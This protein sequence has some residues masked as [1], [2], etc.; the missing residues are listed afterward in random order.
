MD[1]TDA[2][3]GNRQRVVGFADVV[4]IPLRRWRLVVAAAGVVLLAVLAYLFILPATYRAT[5]V[6]VLRPVV[7]DP[8]TLPAGGAD[9]AVNMTAENGV[10]LG[11]EVIDATA[12]A[13]ARE[14]DDVRDAL[15]VE[16]PPG[17]QVLRFEY[18]DSTEGAA[19]TGANAAA[20]TY[21]KVREGI[22][23]QQR[24]SLL[25][26]YDSTMR[27]V[28]EQRQEAQRGLPDTGRLQNIPPR[29]QAML[30]QVNALNDQIAQL[31]NQ[32]AKIAS[33]DLSPGAVT[34]AARAP[35][36]SSRDA[37]PLFLLGGLLGGALIGMML[38]HARETLDRRV[39]SV[40]QAA[41]IVGLPALGVVRSAGRHSEDA[42]AADARYVSLAV[43]K[44]FDQ[45][46]EQ[47]L[48]VLSGQDDEGRAVV[49]G[50]LAVALAEAGRDVWLA[51]VP[52]RH[53]DLRKVLFAAQ[54]RTPPRPRKLSE[55]DSP[56]E[57]INGTVRPGVTP[58][59]GQR[60]EDPEATLIM[61]A[62]GSAPVIA[63][64]VPVPAKLETAVGVD[65]RRSLK[66]LIGSGSVRLCSLGEEPARGVV[67]IDAPPSDV[68]ERGVRAAQGGVAVL[69]V[70][71]DRTRQRELSRLVDRLRSAGA[72]TAGFVLTGGRGA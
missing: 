21:L 5:T 22:Y 63:P 65:D 15:S 71:R 35:V 19:V 39:R 42:A 67:V 62:P 40:D 24:E 60:N 56:T 47:P 68:D 45:H 23:Q 10:A 52:E 26:S 1:V 27:Q 70:A 44:W 59:A 14:P 31:A 12:Q 8:F 18:S 29:T 66:V 16:V 69:V 34:A 9:R 32:R 30:D 37:W 38:A 13:L 3:A 28:T 64:A 33:A 43:L 25:L 20:E 72:R 55:G 50:S 46:P 6:V 54:M 17:G 41:D 4:R 61:R 7:T 11:N 36:P 2:V 48:V 58:V 49:S 51:G 57:T 53:D